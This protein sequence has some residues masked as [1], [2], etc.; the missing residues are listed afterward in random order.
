MALTTVARGRVY[1]WSHAIGRGSAT[2]TGFNYV[3]TMCL[4]KAGNVYTANRGN[5]NNFGMR[6]NHVKVGGP[7]EEELLAEFFEHGEEEGKSVWPFGVAVDNER[8]RVYCSDEWTNTISVFDLTGKFLNKIGKPGSGDGELCRPAGLA[9]EAS[10]NLIVVDSGN[11]RLQVFSP[12]GKFVGKCG[13]PGK[14]PGEFNQPWG[15]T[16]DKDGNIYVADWKNHRVQ[17]LSPQGKPLMCIGSFGKITKPEGSYAVTPL[18]PYIAAEGEKA[19]H[20]RTDQFNHPTDVAVDSDGDI[21]VCDWGNHRVCVFDPEG[22]PIT[23][24]IGDAQELSKWGRQSVDAN[25]DMMKARRRVK[26]LEPQWRLCFPT[27]VDFDPN[28][29]NLIIADGQRNRLQV[30]KKVRN[31]TDFQANL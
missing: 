6:V 17:K 14:A 30:Y 15:I 26:S 31:Y 10:G 18:G 3:Q 16:L 2:G 22:G 7:N 20:P 19:G 13:G 28:T 12:D 24:L 27:A 4:D 5:E 25:P 8:G 1:D 21:Y 9:V 11:N 23:T 29:D